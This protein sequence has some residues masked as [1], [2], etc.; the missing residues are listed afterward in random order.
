MTP[1]KRPPASPRRRSCRC[2]GQRHPNIHV[3][4]PAC[5]SRAEHRGPAHE[6]H[7]GHLAY[8]HLHSAIHRRDDDA[9][10]AIDVAAVVAEV[11]DVDGVALASLDRGRH[12]VAAD[13]RHDDHLGIVDR[14][15][16]AGEFVTLPLEVDEVAAGGPF[17][18]RTAVPGTA[19]STDSIWCRFAQSP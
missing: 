7:V 3:A 19:G 6:L 9:A 14:E 13:R 1:A 5:R 16:V 4:V 12:G 8:R 11:A 15:A 18:E 10:E 17:G 2:H